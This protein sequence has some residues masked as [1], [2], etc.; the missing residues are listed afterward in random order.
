MIFISQMTHV[1]REFYSPAIIL[2]MG[3]PHEQSTIV[4]NDF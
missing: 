1:A 2:Q 4:P 3:S